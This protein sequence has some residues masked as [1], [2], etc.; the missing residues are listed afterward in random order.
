MISHAY[1]KMYPSH[2]FVYLNHVY[3]TGQIWFQF[4][5]DLTKVDSHFP[6]FPSPN[7]WIIRTG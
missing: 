4:Y 6:L 3:V 2:K 7:L 5:F 1:L